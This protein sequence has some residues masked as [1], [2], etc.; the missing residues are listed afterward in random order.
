V[1]VNVTYLDGDPGDPTYTAT[2]T[3]TAV[4]GTV[5]YSVSE[6]EN[7]NP[8]TIDPTSGTLLAGQQATISITTTVLVPEVIVN[9]GGTVVQFN[10]PPRPP[11]Q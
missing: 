6:Y 10:T 9:P 4:G 5:S 7:D 11:I 3:F 1:P 8:I 2:F